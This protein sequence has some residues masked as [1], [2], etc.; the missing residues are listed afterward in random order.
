MIPTLLGG[1]TAEEFLA[2]YWQK[3]PLLVRGALPGF[4][5]VPGVGGRDDMLAL[6]ARDDVESR[7]VS[8]AGGWT[9][10]HGPFAP[11]ALRRRAKP[12]TVLVQGVNLLS[13]E[14][15]R[16]MREFDFIPYARLD[17]LMV[18][19]ATDGGGVGPHFDSYDVF[20]LQGIGRRRWRIGRQRDQTLI[21]GLPV[22]ILADFRP[23]QEWLLE[24]GD[25]LYLPPEWAHDGVAEGEC[26]TWSIGFRAF[27]AQELAEQFLMHLQ[28]HVRLEGRYRDPGLRRQK[29]PAQIGPDMLDQ[30]AAMLDKISW[31]RDTVRDFLGCMLTEPKPHVFFDPPQRPLAASR[32]A[33]LG[34][35]HGI[36]LDPRTQLLF[37]GAHFYL[38]GEAVD[39]AAA[40]RAALRHLADRRSI[41]STF[42]LSP[43]GLEL[44]HEWYLCGFLA[45][46][47]PKDQS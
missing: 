37:A 5:G 22:R 14:G 28:D 39:V 1:M 13:D 20:L 34:R 26:M 42:R 31:K 43:A 38:N 6:A 30:V 46:R 45:I 21:D 9:L 40:D 15:D 18:S 8:Q 7:F 27:P 2:D 17:D 47:E 11:A 23:T 41:D 32:F 19:Y 3:K 36:R 33:S 4:T 44:L 25:M 16:L 10:D 24:P 29:S 12:W 35:K